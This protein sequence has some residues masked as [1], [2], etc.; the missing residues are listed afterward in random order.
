MKTIEEASKFLLKLKEKK[1]FA[2]EFEYMIG[3]EYGWNSSNLFHYQ[4]IQKA[5]LKAYK[6]GKRQGN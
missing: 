1:E 4:I 3:G 6:L 5:I 2:E